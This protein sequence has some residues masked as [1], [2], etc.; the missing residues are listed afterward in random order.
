[1]GCPSSGVLAGIV[2]ARLTRRRVWAVVLAG[3]GGATGWSG[4]RSPVPGLPAPGVRPLSKAADIGP[5]DPKRRAASV[6][7]RSIV[8]D[9]HSGRRASGLRSARGYPAAVST[10]VGADPAVVGPYLAAALNDE[11]WRS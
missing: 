1:M 10:P 9:S 2:P 3:R 5:A 11:R 6:C 8:S 4:S 7:A